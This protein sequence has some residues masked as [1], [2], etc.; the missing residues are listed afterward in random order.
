MDL[1]NMVERRCKEVTPVLGTSI[2]VTDGID[3]L[4]ETISG[5]RDQA[6]ERLT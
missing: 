4:P 1:D 5:N 6:S 2:S 3:P